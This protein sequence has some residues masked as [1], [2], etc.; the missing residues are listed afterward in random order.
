MLDKHSL[1][2]LAYRV[3]VKLIS[4]TICTDRSLAAA[5][6]VTCDRNSSLGE[7]FHVRVVVLDHEVAQCRRYDEIEQ[8]RV[9][10]KQQWCR[11]F[12]KFWY[13]EVIFLGRVE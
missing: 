12:D 7:P 13:L 4:N 2:N 5:F 3:E 10:D 1:T 9:C 11:R 8:S 6:P